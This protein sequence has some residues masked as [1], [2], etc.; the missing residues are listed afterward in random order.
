MSATRRDADLN[1]EDLA[2][3]RTVDLAHLETLAGVALI[4]GG[5]LMAVAS[6][7]SVG[8]ARS[9]DVADAFAAESTRA[10]HRAGMLA[11]VLGLAVVLAASPTLVA[12]TV[13]TPPL[14]WI[15]AGWIGFA[16]GTTLFAMALGL[17]AIMM[18]A[19]GELARTGAVSPQQVA[20]ELTRQ[21]AILAAFLGGNLA[22]L[23]WLPIGVG[24]ARTPGLP[25][26]LGWIVALTALIAWLSF[27]HV[28][29]FE[30]V[31]SPLWPVALALLGVFVLRSA[32][33]SAT[34]PASRAP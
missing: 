5:L 16:V 11:G 28:P 23:S 27:L 22:F 7:T 13:G 14:K 15:A 12:R 21:P 30:R 4:L 9:W 18:P 25:P 31:G 2:N 26:W 8:A 34:A 17:A 3:A 32:G 24:L 33:L 6:L 29:P 20:D 10:L 19:L 1:R